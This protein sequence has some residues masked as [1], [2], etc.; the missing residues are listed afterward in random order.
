MP[1]NESGVIS[2]RGFRM[3]VQGTPFFCSI[4]GDPIL[5]VTADNSEKPFGHS[6][7]DQQASVRILELTVERHFF[8][9]SLMETGKSTT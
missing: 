9:I 1:I 3:G 4:P 2:N 7:F 8:S 6:F 5:L